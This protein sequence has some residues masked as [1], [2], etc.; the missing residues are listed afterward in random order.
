M[1]SGMRGGPHV[2]ALRRCSFTE[3][4]SDS[5]F[6]DEHLP[7]AHLLV[8]ITNRSLRWPHFRP[9]AICSAL[10][11][12]DAPMTKL[13]PSHKTNMGGRPCGPGVSPAPCPI[14]LCSFESLLFKIRV[15]SRFPPPG[16]RLPCTPQ[17]ST[18]AATLGRSDSRSTGGGPRG[19]KSDLNRVNL[20]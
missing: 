5:M 12:Q 7:K 14:N 11:S 20:T 10:S 6:Y 17:I 18:I 4:E 15:Q 3:T 9:S 16:L 1:H 13:I 2:G 8:S 19:Q